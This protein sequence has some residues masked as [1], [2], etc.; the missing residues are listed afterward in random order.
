M[1]M[2]DFGFVQPKQGRPDLNKSIMKIGI[3]FLVNIVNKT[4]TRTELKM[5]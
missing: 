2:S 1:R 4:K 3:K 5:N